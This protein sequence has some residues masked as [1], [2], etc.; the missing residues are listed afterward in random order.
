[1]Q[2][3][4]KQPVQNYQHYYYTTTYT[5]THRAA[6]A[7]AQQA[8]LSNKSPAHQEAISVITLN[9]LVYYTAVQHSWYKVIAYAFHLQYS[10]SINIGQY[11]VQAC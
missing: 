10:S 1:V 3:T 9:P 2:H 6:R 11:S 5:T 4:D 8:F 7:T